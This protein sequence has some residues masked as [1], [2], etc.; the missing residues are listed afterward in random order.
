MGDDLYDVLNAAQEVFE[1]EQILLDIEEKECREG[2]KIDLFQGYADG[3]FVTGQE[4]DNFK[5]YVPD[6][7]NRYLSHDASTI[8]AA[9]LMNRFPAMP[10]HVQYEFLRLVVKKSGRRPRWMSGEKPADAFKIKLIMKVYKY[11]YE[12]AKEV[13][14][15]FTPQQFAELEKSMDT[16]GLE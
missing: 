6:V 16:G 10:N 15:L 3:I 8:M 5:N 1:V 4:F 9:S 11:S 2:V 13:V 14:D 7:I 12:K